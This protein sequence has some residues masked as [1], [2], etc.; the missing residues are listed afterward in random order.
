LIGLQVNQGSS[1]LPPLTTMS[2][3]EFAII[4]RAAC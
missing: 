2:S 4:M 3:K 1:P